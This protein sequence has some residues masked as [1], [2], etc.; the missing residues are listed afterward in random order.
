M[1]WDSSLDVWCRVRII[2]L[3]LTHVTPIHTMSQR[4]EMNL[5]TR[6]RLTALATR[7]MTEGERAETRLLVSCLECGSCD[8]VLSRVG[9]ALD[10]KSV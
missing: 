8:S 7:C 2:F 6:A 1:R 9:T 3:A 5:T 10:L 4:D